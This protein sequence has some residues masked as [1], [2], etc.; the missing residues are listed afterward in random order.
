MT[1]CLEKRSQ[2]FVKNRKNSLCLKIENGLI[3]ADCLIACLLLR[4]TSITDVQK[5]VKGI[6]LS[7]FFPTLFDN[8]K[9]G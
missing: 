2:V 1:K 3:L 9:I 4:K 5:P 7:F 6:R 8:L